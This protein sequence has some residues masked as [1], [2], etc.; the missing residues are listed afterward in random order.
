MYF[1]SPFA[2]LQYLILNMSRVLYYTVPASITL[3]LQSLQLD[4]RLYNNPFASI[5][6]LAR[7]VEIEFI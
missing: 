5:R 7:K 2:S 3:P 6:I 4:R 1:A